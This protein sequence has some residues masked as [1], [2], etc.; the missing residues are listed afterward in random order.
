MA[1]RKAGWVISL[2][3]AGERRLVSVRRPLLVWRGPKKWRCRNTRLLRPRPPPPI[4]SRGG[5]KAAIGL[6]VTLEEPT[7]EMNRTQAPLV[8]TTPTSGTAT[9]QNSRSS[10]SGSS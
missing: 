2:C 3:R 1:R 7:R 10:A 6:F 8:S 4:Y 5:E 9:T